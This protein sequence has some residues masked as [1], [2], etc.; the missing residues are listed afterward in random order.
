M[1]S[2]SHTP[3][4]ETPL[5]EWIDVSCLPLH[6]F[7]FAIAN[8]CFG[9]VLGI[10]LLDSPVAILVVTV[11][12]GWAAW[13]CHVAAWPLIHKAVKTNSLEPLHD[14]NLTLLDYFIVCM[15]IVL[16]ATYGIFLFLLRKMDPAAAEPFFT[17][18]V[19]VEYV[20]DQVFPVL[21]NLESRLIEHGYEHRVAIVRHF[22]LI[23]WL[24]LFVSI[25]YLIWR[26]GSI[27]VR[28][29]YESYVL[30]RQTRYYDSLWGAIFLQAL[31]CS[32][33]ITL[34]NLTQFIHFDSPGPPRAGAIHRSDFSL[35]VA[36][37][38]V[39]VSTTIFL[40]MA[41]A[42]WMLPIAFVRGRS[43]R[44]RK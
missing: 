15:P 40:P 16:S 28:R 23:S 2:D 17:S 34:M 39:L 5:S 30:R 18:L 43:A 26:G 4:P 20:F 19:S 41:Y 9:F 8:L 7:L 32:L 27:G 44:G 11:I 24:P 37:C 35:A 31:L 25:P 3:E 14:H 13:R 38:V 6:G 42:F 36:S 33:S 10:V 12:F 1:L 29:I 22:T 21:R